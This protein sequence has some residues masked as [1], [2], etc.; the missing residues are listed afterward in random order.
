[1]KNRMKLAAI[2]CAFTLLLAE[3]SQ[4]TLALINDF[5]GT[6]T[7]T[8]NGNVSITADPDDASNNVLKATGGGGAF[9]ALVDGFNVPNNSLGTVFVRVR[10][11]DSASGASPGSVGGFGVTN[12]D[13]A[14]AQTSG[15]DRFNPRTYVENIRIQSTEQTQS[16]VYDGWGTTAGNVQATA[17]EVWQNIW[18]VLDTTNN[19]FDM[20]VEGG[21]FATQTQVADDYAWYRTAG[22]GDDMIGFYVFG[23]NASNETYYDDIYVDTAGENLSNPTLTAVPE[24]SSFLFGLTVLG[25]V[26]RQRQRQVA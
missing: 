22:N 8:S 20:Y 6:G 16:S 15:Q 12:K 24:P 7:Y 21:S 23:T 18:F 3:S 5:D 25:L 26:L 17:P 1:M 10:L 13:W 4:A 2:A 11:T 14:G 9:D 19:T